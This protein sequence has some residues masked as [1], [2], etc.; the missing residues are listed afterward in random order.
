VLSQI[1]LTNRHARLRYWSAI[2]LYLMILVLGSIP[3]ARAD[4][5]QVAS[6]VVLHSCAYGGLAFLLFTGGRGSAVLRGIKAVLTVALMGALDETVQSFFPYRHAAVS[7][8]LV[9]CSA[10]LLAS[11]LMWGLWTR[12]KVTPA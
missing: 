5:G 2:V 4:I 8:W 7:D 10:A 3:N 12:F 1:F 11:L 6:G 9:D